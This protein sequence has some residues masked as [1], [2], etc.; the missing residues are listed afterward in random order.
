MAVDLETKIEFKQLC[1]TLEDVAKARDVKK[2]EQILQT[3]F[4]KC[5]C[6][7]DK[8]KVEYPKSDISLYPILRLIL[9]HLER[10]RGPHNLKQTSLANLYARVCGF[11]KN[12][13]SYKKLANYRE[14]TSGEFT[15]NDFA[16]RAYSVLDKTLPRIST[17]FTIARINAFLDGISKKSAHVTMEQKVEMFRVLFR[18][19][20]GFEM[21]WVTRIVLKNLRLGIGTERILHIYHPDA[22]DKFDVTSDL[23]EI[24]YELHDPKIKLKCGIQIFSHFKPMLLERCNIEN[25]SKLFRGNDLYY[26]QTKFDGERSQL[27][28]KDGIF[29]YLTRRGFDITKNSGYGE[30]GSSGFLTTVFTR[31]LNPN[32]HSFIL[33][34]EIMAWHKEKKTFSTKGMNL[35]VKKLSA[36]SRHQPCFVAFD[37][38]LHNDTLLIDTPYKD[39]LKLLKDMFT[40]EEG[41]LIVCQSTLTSNREEL[42]EA[43]NT[44]LRN[45]EE[46]LVVK[47]YNMKYKPNVRDGNGCYKIKAEYSDNL[48]QDIDLIVLGGYYGE[49]K[50][51]GKIKSF[52]MGVAASA[53]NEG[54]NPSQFFSVVSVSSGIGDEMLLHLHTKFAPYWTKEHPENIIGPKGNQPDLWIYPKHSIILTIR[55][56][57][58][59]R[60]KEYPIGYSLRF[61]RVMNVRP[62]KPWHSTCTTRE[63]LSLAKDGKM[64]QK[65]TKREATLH[66]IDQVPVSKSKLQK[67]TSRDKSIEHNVYSKRIVP[68]TRLLDG[69]EICVING[70]DEL[71][72]EQIEEILQQ[73]SAKIVQNPMN[74]T[75][76]VIVGN[77][78]TIRGKEVI[79][80][81]GKYDVVTLDW[82]KRVTNQSDWASLNNF[83]PWELL[84]SRDITR[85]QVTENY[86]EYYDNFINDADEESLKRSFGKIAK[87]IVF[88]LADNQFTVE[89][90]ELDKELFGSISPYSLF[91]DVIGFF[92]NQSCRAK[93][94]FRFMSGTVKD[95]IDNSVTH[96]FVE[97]NETSIIAKIREQTSTKIVKC[98][99]IEECFRNGR[100]CEITNYL[101][102]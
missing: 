62:D 60:S 15:G 29:K 20:T 7:G 35:D 56:T 31:C 85:H 58:M 59:I 92:E 48:V 99:W 25:I 65:L 47:K 93:F 68:L 41:S 76:C 33:D 84:C 75:F 36:T 23:R 102:D 3:F 4:D 13:D 51:T 44:C 24:C 66:D 52:M 70:V 53:K 1:D 38:I 95:N 101:I 43:F 79:K 32:C 91:R 64:I 82:F 100:I 11:A 77:N 9:P 12:S 40:E 80:S 57:E 54:E 46:G 2:K 81:S 67:T 6:I 18:Q 72:K 97:D 37:V 90:I 5:R 28:M 45:N 39:R 88:E 19:I 50:Y 96:A 22:N 26:V 14:S 98:K 74:T 27:H 10:Q 55:A 94:K 86:D 69:K 83:L 73:H 78:R 34:G 49:G 21:K 17:G 87:P 61:P 8:L 30:T 42:I 71:P 89:Q 63:F 16:D